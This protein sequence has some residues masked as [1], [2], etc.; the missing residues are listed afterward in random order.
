MGLSICH[1]LA[2]ALGGT[3]DLTS[4]VGVGSTFTLRVPLERVEAPEAPVSGVRP[5]TLGEA[6]MLLVEVNPMTQ[7]VFR[8]LIEPIVGSLDCVEDGFAAIAAIRSGREA[9]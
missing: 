5:T 8:G 2:K 4:E 6:R 7:G 9:A 3:I 1:N